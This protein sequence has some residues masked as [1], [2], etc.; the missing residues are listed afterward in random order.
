MM[1]RQVTLGCVAALLV[2]IGAL[3]IAA[4][5]VADEWEKTASPVGVD[6]IK[7]LLTDHKQ[8]TLYWDRASRARRPLLGRKAADRSLSA[9]LEFMRVGPNVIGHAQDDQPPYK[10]C[11]FEVAVGEGG[12]TFPGCWGSD[13]TMTYEPHDRE[14]PFKG[15]TDGMVLWLAPMK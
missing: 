10:E 15:R 8:W 13:T 6:A 5:A 12:S 9:T 4:G 3:S 1:D 2:S 11:E 7:R 14:Y